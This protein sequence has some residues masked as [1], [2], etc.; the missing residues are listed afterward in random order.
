MLEKY[1][2]VKGTKADASKKNLSYNIVNSLGDKNLKAL[3]KPN[4]GKKYNNNI[5]KNRS[6]KIKGLALLGRGFNG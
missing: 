5:F 2:N 3:K 4:K 6:N 1:I